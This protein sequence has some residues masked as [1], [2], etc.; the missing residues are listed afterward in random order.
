VALHPWEQYSS[1]LPLRETQILQKQ[2]PH[3]ELNVI[4]LKSVTCEIS[5][6]SSVQQMVVGQVA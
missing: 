1:E 3:L 4:K 5:Y 6:S 2:S